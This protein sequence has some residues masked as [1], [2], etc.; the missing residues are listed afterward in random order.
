MTDPSDSHLAEALAV[1]LKVLV[2]ELADI[3]ADYHGLSER[4]MAAADDAEAAG[5]D[6]QLDERTGLLQ[7]NRLF[8]DVHDLVRGFCIPA[9]RGRRTSPPR[10]RLVD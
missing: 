10:L 4:A 9:A 3:S 7:L 1:R 8:I 2:A 5:G 6:W